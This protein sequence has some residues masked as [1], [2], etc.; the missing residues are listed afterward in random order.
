MYLSVNKVKETFS[1]LE[2]DY[3]YIITTIDDPGF[4]GILYITYS[5]NGRN[6][7]RIEQEK[8]Y[9]VVTV[10]INNEFI[11]LSQIYKYLNQNE[12]VRADYSTKE[13]AKY[14]QSDIKKYY[15]SFNTNKE[16]LTNE[17]IDKYYNDNPVY[18]LKWL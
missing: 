11:S 7:I 13:D 10:K 3:Q 4:N 2:T 17:N 6:D 18:T 15:E 12:I 14:L 8:S 16:L 9:I 5:A 1:F